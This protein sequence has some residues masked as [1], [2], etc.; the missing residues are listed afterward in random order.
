[1]SSSAD[2]FLAV[3]EGMEELSLALMPSLVVVFEA[4]LFLLYPHCRFFGFAGR[5]VSSDGSFS[6][7]S[8]RSCVALE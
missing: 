3:E 7:A 1:V 5:F 4:A 2:F 8:E 6:L